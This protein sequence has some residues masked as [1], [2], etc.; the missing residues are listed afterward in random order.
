MHNFFEYVWSVV[1]LKHTYTHNMTETQKE[2]TRY[3]AY[4]ECAANF[5]NFT[6]TYHDTTQNTL[7]ACPSST[8]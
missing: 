6:N 4:Q 3:T 1:I 5:T 2:R 8:N 7:E